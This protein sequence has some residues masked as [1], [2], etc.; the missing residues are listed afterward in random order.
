VA[1]NAPLALQHP[2]H[3]GLPSTTISATPVGVVKYEAT[4]AKV[5]TEFPFEPDH[6]E[7]ASDL[8]STDKAPDDVVMPDF[9][10]GFD[11]SAITSRKLLA[12]VSDQAIP[13]LGVDQ[14]EVREAPLSATVRHQRDARAKSLHRAAENFTR[15][16]VRPF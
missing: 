14:F 3:G 11:E 5:F 9:D 1:P 16:V 12:P 7:P 6:V 2:F 8:S 15:G 13:R 10:D 4:G